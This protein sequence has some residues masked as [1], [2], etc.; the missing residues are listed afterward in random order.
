M[1][2]E[3]KRGFSL[4]MTARAATFL[5]REVLMIGC[6]SYLTDLT[7]YRAVK[8]S[9]T[10]YLWKEGYIFVILEQ[11]LNNINTGKVTKFAILKN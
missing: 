4:N 8:M 9:G 6:T 11:L 3:P 2:W 5:I 1:D 10:I 7:S